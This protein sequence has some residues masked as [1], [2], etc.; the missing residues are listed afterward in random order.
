M[1][2]QL[3]EPVYFCEGTSRVLRDAGDGVFADPLIRA[4]IRIE[5]IRTGVERLTSRWTNLSDRV[6]SIQPEI[7]LLTGFQTSSLLIPGVSYNGNLWG[8]GLE[9]KGFSHNGEP[10]VFD[11]R[12]TS[13]PAATVSEGEGAFLAL[14]A[15]DR[16]ESSLRASCAFREL[17]DGRAE[18]CLLYPEIE[19]PLTYS[20]RDR[21]GEALEGFITLPAGGVFTAEAF[22]LSGNPRFRRF[23]ARETED[24]ALDLL[25][26]PFIPRYS[27]EEIESLASSFALSLL[28]DVGGRRL[29]S[30]GLSLHGNGVFEQNVGNE[31]GW[32]GQNGMFAKLMLQ[33]W[34][35]TGDPAWKKIA[36]EILDAFG[37]TAGK[38]GLL[39]A[40]Y[41]RYLARSGDVEDTCNLGYVILEYVLCRR[42]MKK[43]GE[44]R[45]DWL[46]ISRSAADFL[47][48]RFSPEYGFGKAWNVETGEC[49]DPEGTIGAYVIPGL[50]ALYEET[51]EE[52]YL[53]SAKTA[54]RFYRD[55]DLEIFRCTAGALDTYCIDK[56]SSGPILHGALMLYDV[57][58]E[59][60]WLTCAEK[61]GWYFSSWMYHFDALYPPES[62]FVRYGFR[63]LGGT[64]VSAQH[65]HIDPWGALV[66]PDLLRL[67]DLTGDRHW[68]K[69]GLLM[70][71][72][73]MENLAPPGGKTVH[74]ILR[75]P[76]A[77]NEGYHHC[78]WG[79]P[80]APG[81]LNDWLVAWPQAFLWNTAVRM[82]KRSV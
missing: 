79:D 38:T 39:R 68:E 5:P 61:A 20:S 4:E 41:D 30:I 35:D 43:M 17:P 78:R 33:K 12:R 29:F 73:A 62:D 69:R 14:F 51:G 58:K 56:E 22:V 37:E 18:H 19:R 26:K 49:V 76:G 81:Y 72:N 6:L 2:Y 52:K 54:L 10:W 32:C 16:D 50:V 27:P 42:L 74:G 53:S 34:A 21:Y 36:V 24:A 45:P 82:R 66:V 13:I 44:D 77:Q 31:F 11:Y 7:R 57:E 48:E 1:F 28:Q 65:H 23:A 70:W 60:E 71:A 15:S 3:A 67:A 59:D 8:R 55:R 47:I 80:K 25:G 63:T 75:G 40:H 64:S 46:R 9:P